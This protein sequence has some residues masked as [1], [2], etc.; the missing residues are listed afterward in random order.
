MTFSF[1]PSDGFCTLT[2][3][4]DSCPRNSYLS[5]DMKGLWKPCSDTDSY[6]P[7]QIIE[8]Y[9][10]QTMITFEFNKAYE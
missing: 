5:F 4:V 8:K 3:F 1:K 10:Y 9:F 2:L 6:I 7:S